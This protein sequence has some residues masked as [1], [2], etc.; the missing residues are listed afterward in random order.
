MTEPPKLV[1]VVGVT[2][3]GKSNL[4]IRLAE[5][6]DGE[7]ICADSSTVRK[8]MDIGTAKP[9][10]ED[11]DRVPHHLLD[12]VEPDEQF[13]AADFK[14]QA[15]DA[16]EDVT[17]RGKLPIMVGG[18]GLYIDG[19]LFSYQFLPRK[20]ANRQKLEEL[21]REKLLEIAKRRN[22]DV[23]KVDTKN[24]RRLLRLIETNGTSATKS[25]LRSNTLIIGLMSERE[26]LKSSIEIRLNSM[27]KTGLEREVKNL[28]GK[29]GWDSQG[30]QAIGYKEWRKYFSGQGSIKN[31]QSAIVKNSINLAKKQIT[32]FKRNSAIQWFTTPVKVTEVVDTVTTFLNS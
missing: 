7:I 11:Q 4:A 31:V 1:V 8:G 5:R 25:D 22:I 2:G 12:I 24:P 19:V 10:K 20:D 23:S 13:T 28:S 6:F 16:I 15:L 27:L 30:L 18:S 32:W 29:Y 26:I 17:N 3:S 21:S 14:L 9:S